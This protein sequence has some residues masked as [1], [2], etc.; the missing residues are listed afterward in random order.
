MSGELVRKRLQWV[1]PDEN[2]DI[3]HWPERG[4]GNLS[5]IQIVEETKNYLVVYK[6][7]NLAVQPGTGH[8]QDNLV[9]W[10]IKHYPEQEQLL[11]QSSF[12][13]NR[14]EAVVE[15]KE[16]LN[17]T[18]GLV[19]RLDKDAQGILLVARSLPMLDYFQ[20][21][22][23]N[24]TV[25]K[26]Y[27][28]VLGGLLGEEVEVKSWQVRDRRNPIRQKLFW[29]E[30]EAKNY[31]EKSRYAES[32]FRPKVQC[33][34]LNQTLVE[35]EIRTGRMHQIRLQTEGLGF[36]LVEDKV[37]G[38]Q[39]SIPPAPL[40]RGVSGAKQNSVSLTFRQEFNIQEEAVKNI[41]A[42][43]TPINIEFSSQNY[44]LYLK[45]K[46]FGEVDFCLLSNY[47]EVEYEGARKNWQWKK[48]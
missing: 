11:Y 34:E 4:G 14:P 33:P 38:K 41:D 25:K 9:N 26:K 1:F 10:L 42:V 23:R 18:A 21:Q 20:D 43:K 6:P 48:A 28:A 24:H 36:P 15:A 3:N 46:I 2:T 32:T 13:Q 12:H 35:V 22:F 30:V 19:H 17:P 8:A 39:H 27:L 5:D 45:Q 31:D 16:V 7:H 40:D 29:S 47:L 44:F 37:Y